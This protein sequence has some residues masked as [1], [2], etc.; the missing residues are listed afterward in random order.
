LTKKGVG[1]GEGERRRRSKTPRKDEFT[2]FSQERGNAQEMDVNVMAKMR[3][4][5]NKSPGKLDL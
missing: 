2:E 5:D 3:K 1:G 4:K